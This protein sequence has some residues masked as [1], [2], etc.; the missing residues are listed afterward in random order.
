MFI[1]IKAFPCPAT[2]PKLTPEELPMGFRDGFPNK[3]IKKE[4]QKF[5][6]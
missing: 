6:R 5:V 4:A 1:N 3:K 2:D